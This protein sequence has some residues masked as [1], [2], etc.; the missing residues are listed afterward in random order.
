MWLSQAVS[1]RGR[2]FNIDPMNELEADRRGGAASPTGNLRF[3][4]LV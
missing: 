4:Q 2:R 1:A 3:D